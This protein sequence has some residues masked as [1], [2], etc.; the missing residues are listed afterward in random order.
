MKNGVKILF[1][2]LFKV[3]GTPFFLVFCISMLIIAYCH[4]FIEWI[5]DKE[6]AMVE[7]RWMIES[8]LEAI[9]DWF[10]TI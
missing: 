9:K 6:Y 5:Y 3:I 10:T 7:T 4:L 2:V 1:R 8:Y